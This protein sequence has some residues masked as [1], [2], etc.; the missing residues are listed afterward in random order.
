MLKKYIL[1]LPIVMFTAC[2]EESTTSLDKKS[3]TRIYDNDQFDASFHPIDMQQTPDGGFI[4]L[5][6][7]SESTTDE[8]DEIVNPPLS[9]YILKVDQFGNVERELELGDEY[10]NPVA[11]LVSIN[12]RFYFFCM[13]LGTTNVNLVDIDNQ[14]ITSAI[15]PLDLPLT[16][17]LAAALDMTV[18]TPTNPAGLLLLSYNDLDKLSTVSQIS[19]TGSVSTSRGFTIAENSLVDQ[20]I[21]EHTLRTGKQYPFSVGHTASGLFYYNGFLDVT[22]SLVFT[23]LDDNDDVVGIV[24]GQQQNGGFSSILPITNSTFATSIFNFGANFFLPITAINTSS[25]TTSTTTLQETAFTFPELEANA[26]VKIIRATRKG[27][28]VLVYGSNT[29]SKQIGLYFYD[30]ATGKFLDSEYIGYSNPFEIASVLQTTQGDLV[31][32]GT[33]YIAG[34]LP[35]FCLIKL[36]KSELKGI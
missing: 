7:K 30:E 33:T 10:V 19:T 12:D 32:S 26:R 34:R 9:V 15:V 25:S 31:V 5:G 21:T 4:I 23:N 2:L 18:V 11:N 20:F 28:N 16:K 17:P 27:K 14:A 3:F 22:F 1:L 8:G 36:S 13:E 35:R 29:K 6:G 24:N